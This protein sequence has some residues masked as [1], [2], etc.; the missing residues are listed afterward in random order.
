[1]YFAN[2]MRHDIAFSINVLAI[3]NYDPTRRLW[4]RIKYIF[5]YL[6]ETHDMGLF[7]QK[8]IKSKLVVYANT[9]YLSDL[10]EVR[11]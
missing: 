9:W 8:H 1:M 7:Y 5:H 10:L 4:N 11:L 6:Y 2:N 3:Y